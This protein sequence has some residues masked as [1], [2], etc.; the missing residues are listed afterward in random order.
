M[1]LLPSIII[2]QKDSVEVATWG[3]LEG[4]QR[5]QEIGIQEQWILEYA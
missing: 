1:A 4:T 5:W 2:D 3:T